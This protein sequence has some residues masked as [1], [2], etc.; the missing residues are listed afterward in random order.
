VHELSILTVGEVVIVTAAL[1]TGTYNMAVYFLWPEAPDRLWAALM[2]YG[3]AI[4]STGAGFL[5]EADLYSSPPAQ[6][7]TLWGGLIVAHASAPYLLTLEGKNIKRGTLALIGASLFIWSALLLGTDWVFKDSAHLLNLRWDANPYYQPDEGILNLACY[8]MVLAIPATAM[9]SALRRYRSLHRRVKF[10]L[11]AMLLWIALATYDGIAGLA[12]IDSPPMFFLEYGFVFLAFQ[13]FADSVQEHAKL[14]QSA[15]NQHEDAKTAFDQLAEGSPDPIFIHRHN[16]ILYANPAAARVL[17]YSDPSELLGLRVLDQIHP[18]DHLAELE[19][20][21][22]LLRG[23]LGLGHLTDRIRR[24]DG[25]YAICELNSGLIHILGKRAI[26]A[27]VRDIS[28]ETALKSKMMAMDRMIAIG[29]LASGVAHEIN[30]PLSYVKAN[31]EVTSES[32]CSLEHGELKQEAFIEESREVLAEASEGVKRISRIVED[33]RDTAHAHDEEALESEDLRAT[34][35]GAL[36]L[37]NHRIKHRAEIHTQLEEVPN[38]LSPRGRLSQVFIN[39]LANAADALKDGDAEHHRI[40]VRCRLVGN[41]VVAEVEDDGEGIPPE[42]LP[43]IF[44][45][46]YTTKKIGEGTGL[47]LS[48]CQ[49]IVTSCGGSLEVRSRRGAGTCFTISLPADPSCRLD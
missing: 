11:L 28:E 49:R 33:L 19:R 45:A 41:Q 30:N 42:V 43:H 5:Y 10:A 15:V 4:Y 7:L 13:L 14:L 48:I 18:D 39:L 31:I 34:I 6:R 40:L 24:K 22:A 47:G 44:D 9:A 21:K 25:S 35:E 16:S 12:W 20:A 36:R 8:L 26:L 27:I 38:I 32:L 1:L 2:S 23:E 17:G 46:F 37:L 29:T 3:A